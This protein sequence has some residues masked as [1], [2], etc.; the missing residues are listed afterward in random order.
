MKPNGQKLC[1]DLIDPI[2]RQ[3]GQK[4]LSLHCPRF[5]WDESDEGKIETFFK[6]T[7]SMEIMKYLH[8]ISLQN[9]PIGLEKSHRDPSKTGALSPFILDTT[10]NISSSVKHRSS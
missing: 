2:I 6:I 5:F 10:S 7:M 1:Q 9:T 3:I 8:N 4:S